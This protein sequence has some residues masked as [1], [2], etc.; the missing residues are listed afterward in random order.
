MIID[1][2]HKFIFIAVP[3]TASISI[4]FSL[5]YGHDIPEPD[6]YHAGITDV[7]AENACDGYFKFAFVRNPWDR[8]Y[9]LYH[10][11]T[12]KRITQYSQ[13]VK[14][15]KPLLSE[16]EDFNDMCLRLH[17]SSWRNDV[18][19]KSQF[20]QLGDGKKL[21]MDQVGRFETLQSDFNCICERIGLRDV[22]LLHMNQGQCARSYA[23]HY[24][25]EAIEAVRELYQDDVEHFGYEF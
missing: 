4:Q 23:E 14:H 20:N 1:H 25:T 21:L 3:K 2:A 7:L 19:F 18:F 22:P 24:S 11:F 9:S 12:K 16:F 17:E 6:L 5:G 8:L 13:L 10:D 15:D